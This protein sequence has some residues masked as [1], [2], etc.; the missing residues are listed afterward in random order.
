MI[1][2]H[3]HILPGLDDG[4]KTLEDSLSMARSAVE[5]GI[6][7]IIATPHHRNGKYNNDKET[8]IAAVDQL[9]ASLAEENIPLTILPGQETRIHGDFLTGLEEATILPL[10]QTSDYIFVELPSDQ[11]PRYTKQMLF[12]LQVKGYKPII[13]H[14]ERNAKLIKEPDLLYDFVKN[15]AFTQVTAASICGRFG[16]NV[17]K[18]TH[19]LVEANLTHIIATDAHNTTSRGFCIQEAY[20]EIKE[21]YGAAMVYYFVENAKFVA[22][23]S[24]LAAD[25]PEPVKKKKKLFGIFG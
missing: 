25:P 4:A 9:N 17:Q 10:N 7:S 1:D 3:C 24:I 20:Q 19:K 22:E 13:V 8:I 23:G 6:D 2:I 18:F 5:E 15:G 21:N 11:V 12:D 14:P 16:K